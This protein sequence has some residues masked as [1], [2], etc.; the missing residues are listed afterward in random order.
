MGLIG[1]ARSA[2]RR[3]YLRTHGA[4][5][6]Q[7]TLGG[8]KV[9][10]GPC[11][12]SLGKH[13]CRA[14]AHDQGLGRR[15]R[16]GFSAAAGLRVRARCGGRA[17]TTSGSSRVFS[18]LSIAATSAR[19]AS[20]SIGAEKTRTA[21]LLQTGHGARDP[22]VPIG[23]LTSKTPSTTHRYRYCATQ[24]SIAGFLRIGGRIG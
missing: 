18:V 13:T 1:R 24:R 2:T 5:C 7:R 9:F 20:E 4:E 16:A 15:C 14:D 22:A 10:T 21:S 12:L 3:V 23:R 17:D 6:A 11:G 8:R 19:G